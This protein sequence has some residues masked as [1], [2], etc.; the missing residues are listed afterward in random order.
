[1]ERRKL[2]RAVDHHFM[3]K[4]FCGFAVIVEIL[5]ATSVLVSPMHKDQTHVA[6]PCTHA[7]PILSS[8]DDL[9]Q[10]F[11]PYDLAV[12]GCQVL[13]DPADQPVIMCRSAENVLE[14][15]GAVAAHHELDRVWA[16]D[17]GHILR[18]ETEDRDRVGRWCFEEARRHES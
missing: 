3:S 4:L 17:L 12:M 18:I 11:E 13:P 9:D 7:V 15:F 16:V 5:R 10:L 14:K 6:P 1:M 8:I 2:G